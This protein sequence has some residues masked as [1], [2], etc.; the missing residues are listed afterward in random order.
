MRVC[1]SLKYIFQFSSSMLISHDAVLYLIRANNPWGKR[2]HISSVSETEVHLC[3]I[4]AAW[5]ISCKGLRHENKLT[6]PVQVHICFLYNFFHLIFLGKTLATRQGTIVEDIVSI[7]LVQP[8]HTRTCKYRGTYINKVRIRF[9]CNTC[10][11][12]FNP[13]S[14]SGYQQLRDNNV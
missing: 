4:L 6:V 11:H 5:M 12:S 10:V 7:P 9:S 1:K 2:N 8:M 3:A 14:S 13:Y